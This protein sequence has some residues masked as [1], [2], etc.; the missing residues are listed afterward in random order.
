MNFQ[1]TVEFGGKTTAGF[2]VPAKA[3]AAE[4]RLRRMEKSLSLL[5][6]A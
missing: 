2:E 3:D 5:R 4:T 6:E 1:A